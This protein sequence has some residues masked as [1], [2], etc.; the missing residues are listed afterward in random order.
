M[1]LTKEMQMI[2][3]NIYLDSTLPCSTQELYKKFLEKVQ[4]EEIEGPS[5]STVRRYIFQI[6]EEIYPITMRMRMTEEELKTFKAENI[7]SEEDKEELEDLVNRIVN[8]V[9]EY[10]KGKLPGVQESQL[11]LGIEVKIKKFIREY[12]KKSDVSIKDTTSRNY[13]SLITSVK[14]TRN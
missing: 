13:K 8:T 1:V 11:K 9:T 7:F 10:S 14:E 12:I 2:I 4:K 6:Q 5:Y 3:K